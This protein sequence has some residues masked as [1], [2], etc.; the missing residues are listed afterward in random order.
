MDFSLIGYHTSVPKKRYATAL[1]EGYRAL[2]TR[3]FQIFTKNPRQFRVDLV[4][5]EGAQARRCREGAGEGRF[6]VSHAS[7]LLNMANP[8]KWEEKVASGIAELRNISALG[9]YGCVFHVGKSL[10]MPV[11]EALDLMERYIVEVLEGAWEAGTRGVTY[12]IETAAGCGTELLTK[13]PDLGA[14]HKRFTSEKYLGRDAVYGRVKICVDT[15]HIFSAGYGLHTVEATAVTL[16]T[17][18]EHI[19]WENVAC[20]HLNDSLSLKG[21][22]CKLDRHGRIGKGFIGTELR[23]F[24]SRTLT[25]GIPHILETPHEE[26]EIYSVHGEE[27]ALIRSWF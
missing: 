3:V 12:I 8:E 15:C 21:C 9:G 1:E 4:D 27:I 16:A 10:K 22:G 5:G 23:H 20:I 24:L 11:P 18:E 26:S 13:I 19:G 7:Y 6:L 25:L 2:G 17:I 14:F